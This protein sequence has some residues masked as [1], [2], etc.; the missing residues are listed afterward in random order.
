MARVALP[1]FMVDEPKKTTEKDLNGCY[2][3]LLLPIPLLQVETVITKRSVTFYFGTHI[4]LSNQSTE[5]N[6]YF[7]FGDGVL[8]KVGDCVL[9]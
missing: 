1:T 8:N 3:H 9:L 7:C 2:S 6:Y 4:I 5:N